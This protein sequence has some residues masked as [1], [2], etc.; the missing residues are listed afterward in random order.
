MIQHVHA[1]FV[2]LSHGA[3][4]AC[5]ELLIESGLVDGP[6]I[7]LVQRSA[8]R[9]QRKL[10]ADLGIRSDDRCGDRHDALIFPDLL[11][12]TLTISGRN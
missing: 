6:A 1:G 12:E 4:G 9:L 3:F 11:T 7:A 8:Q 2:H 10:I 5:V